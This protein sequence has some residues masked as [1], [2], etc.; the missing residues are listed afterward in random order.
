MTAT[1]GKRSH[2]AWLFCALTLTGSMAAAD[3]GNVRTSL[4][5]D[6]A[7]VSPGIP[8]DVGIR[9]QISPGWHIYWRNPGDSG[10]PPRV[11]W[12][13][14]KGF[15]AGPIEWP[16]PERLLS[17]GLMSYGYTREVILPVRITP[18]ANLVQDSV[19]IVAALAWLECKEACLPGASRLEIS[20]PVSRGAAGEGPDARL[21][22]AARSRLPAE[23]AGWSLAAESGPRAIAL[24]FTTPKG[25]APFGAYLYLDRPLVTEHAAPQGFAR[26]RTG[27]RLTL[28]PAANASGNLDRLSGVLVIEGSGS[29]IRVDV[30]VAPGDPAMAPISAKQQSPPLVASL[31][32]LGI[33]GLGVWLLLRR[34]RRS[35]P[36]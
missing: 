16:V 29:A 17:E 11:T 15:S 13:L 32:V 12:T 36:T 31:V 21:I 5:A 7:S 10:L 27:Y 35:N 18:P 20:L 25:I 8:F 23:P 22:T 14:P 26:T 3:E 4:L 28:Q 1:P 33:A 30:P 34:S 2:L 6:R 19:R 9:F 24:D